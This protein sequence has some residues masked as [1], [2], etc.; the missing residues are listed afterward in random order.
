[1][2][3]WMSTRCTIYVAVG[4]DEGGGGAPRGCLETGER[5]GQCRGHMKEL[6]GIIIHGGGCTTVK[7]QTW[8]GKGVPPPP[9]SHHRF[10]LPPK[11]PPLLEP[12]PPPFPRTS[13]GSIARR[14]RRAALARRS[15][16]SLPPRRPPRGP[17]HISQQ[18]RGGGGLGP[19]P[20][21]THTAAEGG[22]VTEGGTSE[23]VI[24]GPRWVSARSFE[25][26]RGGGGG[27]S[28]YQIT[29]KI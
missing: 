12:K 5:G 4:G 6:P 24:A 15:N 3:R 18:S 21:A 16:P 26:R 8:T 27:S 13:V 1:M 9:L 14:L 20:P 17:C 19:S 10:D 29:N 25:R 2:R 11:T 7:C 28:V 23:R 22:V